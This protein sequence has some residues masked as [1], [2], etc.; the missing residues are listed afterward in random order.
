MNSKKVSTNEIIKYISIIVIVFMSMLLSVSGPFGNTIFEDK[1]VFFIIGREM[2]H[3]KTVYIDIVDQKALYIFLLNELMAF[4]SETTQLGSYIVDSVLLS[5]TLCFVYNTLQKINNEHANINL[6]VVYVA[7]FVLMIPQVIKY[8]GYTEQYILF[9]YIIS[10]CIY[11]Q[12]KKPYTMIYQGILAAIVFNL[13]V[14]YMLFFGAIL[15]D[16]FVNTIKNK[17]YKELLKSIAYGLIGL[18]IGCIP[19]IVYCTV[20]NCWSE[21]LFYSLQLNITYTNEKLNIIN[22]LLSL[23]R[24]S[25]WAA[26]CTIVSI[27]IVHNSSKI[28]KRNKQMYSFAV[29]FILIESLT[30]GG[31]MEGGL[32]YAITSLITTIPL[33]IEIFKLAKRIN[34]ETILLVVSCLLFIVNAELESEV[35]IES[36]GFNQRNRVCNIYNDLYEDRITS[37]EYIGYEALIYNY[38]DISTDKHFVLMYMQYKTFPEQIDYKINKIVE[39]QPELL[40]VE[41][42]GLSYIESYSEALNNYELVT[43]IWEEDGEPISDDIHSIYIRKDLVDK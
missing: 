5:I 20:H 42:I 10:L 25:F 4:I 12:N 8:N 13:K 24:H 2:L 35:N 33:I 11:I 39:E 23:T 29:I 30:G 14:N 27:I 7:S 19:V 3:G 36:Y 6:L 9:A 32:H 28:T 38:I 37:A 40:I 15:I 43:D 21:M 1:A 41:D 18:F 34:K 22:V 16:L 26:I 17:Q 31:Y